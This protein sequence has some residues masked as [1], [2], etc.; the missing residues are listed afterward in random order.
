MTKSFEDK[1][2]IGAVGEKIVRNILFDQ[3]YVVYE[4]VRGEAHPFDKVAV[5][6]KI[7]LYLVEVKTKQSTDKGCYGINTSS[8][9]TYKYFLKEYEIP[10]LVFFVDYNPSV[11]QIRYTTLR[12]LLTDIEVDNKIY[13]YTMSS[14]TGEVNMFHMNSTKLIRELTEE[15][16]NNIVSL[17]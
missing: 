10:M 4:P 7:N 2:K 8:V 1:L 3:G 13:P 11:L 12:N 15:E 14:S 5:K 17:L 6:D 16:N 9:N